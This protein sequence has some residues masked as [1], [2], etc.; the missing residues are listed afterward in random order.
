MSIPEGLDRAPPPEAGLAPL[1]LTLVELIRQLLE[2]QIIRRVDGEALSDAEME[3]A[4]A[5]LQALDRQVETLC[6]VFGLA[7]ADLNW[8]LG[9]AGKLWPQAYYPGQRTEEPSVLELLDRLLD[10]GVVL[11]GEADLGLADLDLIRLRLRV[12]LTSRPQTPNL[13]SP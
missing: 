9:A 7:R 11:E 4:A 2:A 3:R 10:T 13:D 12:M 1:V 8:D 6:E 5:S